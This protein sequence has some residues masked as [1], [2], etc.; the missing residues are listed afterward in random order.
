MWA[1]ANLA[2]SSYQ[3]S[4]W[5]PKSRFRQ[6]LEH[7]PQS[8]RDRA[9]ARFDEWRRRRV[10][11]GELMSLN[12]RDLADLGIG[13]ADFPAILDGTYRRDGQIFASIPEE[14]QRPLTFARGAEEDSHPAPK[15]RTPDFTAAFFPFWSRPSWFERYWY[16]DN[17][18]DE[19]LR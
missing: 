11:L 17:Q 3:R 16:G 7:L 10:L 6:V 1:N 9:I 18:A 15:S 8:V 2:H 4:T 14:H 19:R 5:Q 13:R 12:D